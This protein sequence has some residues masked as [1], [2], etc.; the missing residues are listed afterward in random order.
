M[1]ILGTTASNF[2]ESTPVVSGGT[3]TTDA[4]FVYRSFTSSGTLTVSGGAL[5]ATVYALGG[6][7]NGESSGIFGGYDGEDVYRGGAGGAGG[8]FTTDTT[9]IPVGSS[10]VVIG[11]AGGSATYINYP[12]VTFAIFAQGGTG[13]SLDGGSNGAFFG[14]AF[15]Q[16]GGWPVGVLH[17]G[18]GAGSGGIGGNATSTT[19]GARGVSVSVA[20]LTTPGYSVLGNGGRGN[21]YSGAIGAASGTNGIRGN[22][23]NGGSGG[24]I[25]TAG[26]AGLVVVRYLRSLTGE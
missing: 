2:T 7:G 10:S 23:G 22:G 21:T 5:S 12:S 26:T 4:T 1:R 18:G 3:R 13:G 17:G 14:G 9:S 11:A 24:G 16:D 8:R 15:Y 20:A 6:G 19:G 25:G